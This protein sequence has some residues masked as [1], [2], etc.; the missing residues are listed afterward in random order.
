MGEDA[1]T[2]K[3]EIQ[4][5]KTDHEQKIMQHFLEKHT[6]KE[7]T[8]S[9]TKFDEDAEWNTKHYENEAEDG[10]Q[11]AEEDAAKTEMDD[12]RDAERDGLVDLVAKR[13][14]EENGS[15]YP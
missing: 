1:K 15:Q 6:N 2:K 3:Y 10:V 5:Q 11:A 12:Q 13:D 14:A 8:E 7:D 9:V 4:K